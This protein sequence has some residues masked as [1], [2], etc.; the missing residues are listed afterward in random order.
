[1]EILGLHPTDDLVKS[2]DAAG[3]VKRTEQGIVRTC[4]SP[5]PRPR[6]QRCR[7]GAQLI[8]LVNM[9]ASVVSRLQTRLKR[10]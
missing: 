10:T 8:R 3:A 4:S 7:Y 2:K 1:M 6:R 9:A 5:N